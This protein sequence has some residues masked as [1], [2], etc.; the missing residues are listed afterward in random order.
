M[1]DRL[2]LCLK[3]GG[4][5]SYEAHI[6]RF[7]SWQCMGCGFTTNNQLREG[8]QYQKQF[9]ETLPELYKDLK[10]V[11]VDKKV[12]YPAVLNKPDQGIVFLDG[13]SEDTAQWAAMLATNVLEEE[14]DK[15]VKPGTTDE[16]FTYKMDPKTLRHFDYKTGFMDAMEYIGCF[17]E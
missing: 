16:Y 3:C 13:T 15:F 1:T 7:I 14:K 6:K 8:S 9:E 5:A 17:K 12:W 10:F 4:N 11:D 2:T